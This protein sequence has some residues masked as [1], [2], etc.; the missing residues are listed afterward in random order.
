MYFNATTQQE[1]NYTQSLLYFAASH[2][3]RDGKYNHTNEKNESTL[4]DVCNLLI[5]TN[6]ANQ[7]FNYFLGEPFLSQFYVQFDYSQNTIG[8]NGPYS[9][10]E[11]PI[12]PE[13]K[14]PVPQEKATD[15][16]LIGIIVGGGVLAVALIS[17]ILITMKQKRLKSQLSQYDEG[18][19]Y[20]A[21]NKLENH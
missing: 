15:W 10:V 13:P 11:H 7:Q 8:F 16:V 14:P 21:Y 4:I 12:P 5:Y 17:A 1:G 3:A 19:L 9:N 2:Y 20:E 6:H 18:N